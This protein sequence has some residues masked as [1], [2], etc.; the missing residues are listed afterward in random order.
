M[1]ERWELPDDREM[2][3]LAFTS[4]PEWVAGYRAGKARCAGNLPKG[5]RFM[6]VN[7]GT[8]IRDGFIKGDPDLGCKNIGPD[9]RDHSCCGFAAVV[10]L[11]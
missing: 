8:A 3:R 7:G 4:C 10:I 1:S 5:T 11:D 6:F 2:E 9:A